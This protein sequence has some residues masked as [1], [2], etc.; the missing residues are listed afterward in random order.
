MC[1][2]F[3]G[4][5]P[6]N[7]DVLNVLATV[8]VYQ[9]GVMKKEVD[10]RETV[11]HVF[12]YTTQLSVTQDQKIIVPSED[13]H[14]TIPPVQILFCFKQRNSK[15][16]SSHR[17]L[18]NAFGRIEVVV[19]IDVGT[20]PGIKSILALWEAFYNDKDLGGASGEVHA[21]LGQGWKRLLNPFVA[22]QNFEYKV[23]TMLD[24]PLESVFGY[25]TVLPGAFSA[26]RYRAVIGQPL[27]RYF[28]GD[29]ILAKQLGKKGMEGMN[30]FERNLYMAEDRILCFELVTKAGARWHLSYVKSAKAETDTPDSM[31]EFMIQ[32]RRWLNGTFASTIYSLLHFPRIYKSSHSVIRMM[33]FHVQMIYNVVALIQ[34]W[35]SLAAFLLATFIITDIAGSP[36]GDQKSL[37]FPF[38]A[39]TPIFNAVVQCLYIAFVLF[40][41]ILAL[42]NKVRSERFNYILSFVLFAFVQVYFII[43]VL[44]LF[45]RIFM[46]GPLQDSSGGEYAYITTFYSSVGTLIVWITCGSVFGVYY[47]VSILYLDPWHMFTSYPQYLFVAS[48]Y[49]NILN[50]CA[51]S[52]WHDISWGTKGRDEDITFS[53]PS[54]KSKQGIVILE[55]E[56]RPE[57]DIDSAFE[58]VVK[59]AVT[60]YCE[61]VKEH[62]QTLDE[63]YKNFRTKLVAVYIFS[64]FS[65]CIFVVNQSFDKLSF[66][67]SDRISPFTAV[68][69]TSWSCR[70]IATLTRSG[71]FVSGCGPHRAAFCF[72]LPRAASSLRRLCFF[73]PLQEDDTLRRNKVCGFSTL[74][75]RK[76]GT[77]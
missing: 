15:K 9:D 63:S 75:T 4:I 42:G 48:S 43:N 12:E 70:E 73:A 24:K 36:P 68:G 34:S 25:L 74:F 59:M 45:I 17:W 18:F 51:F 21:M 55:E 77:V 46:E 30:I 47:A 3:D 62:K 65:L 10:G 27:E 53:L 13:G 49:T 11:A 39:A 28:L 8:G 6:C 69:L 64:N 7:K 50:V 19:T 23:N 60:P 71:S 37:A 16:I 32:R 38:G 35:F 57:A 1:L 66:L 56:D 14:S 2:I 41:F 54:T 5:D 67:V 29:P 52:N 61:P 40:Q 22:A 20:K 33:L 58:R 44:Y 76:I 31:A 26:Y 72:G